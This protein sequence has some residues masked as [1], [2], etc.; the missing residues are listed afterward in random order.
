L[1]VN[2]EIKSRPEGIH[3]YFSPH[4][5][6]M[7]IKYSRFRTLLFTFTL[8][9]AMVSIYARLSG[10]LSE[11][12]VN[13]PQI[14]SAT[15]IIIRLCPELTEGKRN[16]FYREDGDIYFSKEKAIKYTPSGGGG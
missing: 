16:K 15:P 5:L 13:I 14:E 11:V 1:P 6:S 9:L 7:K 12:P 3:L 10:Y 8:G 4:H 2:L